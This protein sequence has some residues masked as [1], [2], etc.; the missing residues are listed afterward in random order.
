[1]GRS[2]QRSV[3]RGG[4]SRGSIAH[5]VTGNRSYWDQWLAELTIGSRLRAMS[6]TR[7]V[8]EQDG[9]QSRRQIGLTGVEVL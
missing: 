8:N 9:V 7:F 2:K 6:G 4:W 3:I 5:G 1:M